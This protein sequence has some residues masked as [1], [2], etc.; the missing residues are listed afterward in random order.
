ME[1]D[2]TM[3][4]LRGDLGDLRAVSIISQREEDNAADIED[5]ENLLAAA[6]PTAVVIVE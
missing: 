5:E 3:Q 2:A 6:S 1:E 4:P